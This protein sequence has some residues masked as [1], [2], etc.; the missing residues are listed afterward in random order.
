MHVDLVMIPEMN[1]KEGNIT[2]N[3]AISSSIGTAIRTK[4]AV[5]FMLVLAIIWEDVITTQN[6]VYA[7]E[8]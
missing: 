7:R 4:P 8:F 3:S 6:M 1:N 5:L 2:S